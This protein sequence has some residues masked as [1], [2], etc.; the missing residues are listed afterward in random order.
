[1]TPFAG[2]GREQLRAMYHEAWRKSRSG[3]PLTPLEAQIADVVAAHPE[4]HALLESQP[5]A[6]EPLQ[7]GSDNPYLH[8]GL[9]LAL[10]E[11]LSTDRPHGVAAIHRRLAERLGAHP[12]EHRMIQVLAEV[13]WDAQRSGRMGD[14]RDYFERLAR[15]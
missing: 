2:Q 15:L 13:L 1:M 9:H 6:P 11:Q 5:G 3:T 7:E 4:Y 8:L 10:R 12:A 14:E